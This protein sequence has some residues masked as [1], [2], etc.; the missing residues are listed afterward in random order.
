MSIYRTYKQGD[1]L[2]GVWKVDAKWFSSPVRL[3][4]QA[5]PQLRGNNP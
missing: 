3:G 4:L 5:R 2:V 1:L